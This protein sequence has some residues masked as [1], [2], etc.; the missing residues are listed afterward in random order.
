M[1]N[2]SFR[3]LVLCNRIYFFG[4]LFVSSTL[5]SFFSY[6]QTDSYLRLQITSMQT[7]FLVFQKVLARS[8]WASRCLFH[9][10]CFQRLIDQWIRSMLLCVCVSDSLDLPFS[11]LHS[12]R[13]NRFPSNIELP[14]LFSEWSAQMSVSWV[15]VTL[16]VFC[17]KI[18]ELNI[19]E[20]TEVNGPGEHTL[21]RCKKENIG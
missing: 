11:L 6:Y 15:I 5:C 2:W 19:L 3:V 16:K 21:N 17:W 14:C 9:C 18:R 8:S 20:V 1:E 4:H 10:P 13:A 12:D 7:S